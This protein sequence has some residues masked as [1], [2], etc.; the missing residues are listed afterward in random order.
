MDLSLS[1]RTEGDRTIVSVGGELA[2]TEGLRGYD[3]MHLAAALAI[4]AEILSS[5]DDDLCDAA[6]RR[7]TRRVGMYHFEIVE[8][9]RR[10]VIAGIVFHKRQLKPAHRPV[11]PPFS[12]TLLSESRAGR[13]QR[14][15]LHH[16]LTS[17]DF[18]G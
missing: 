17:I 1:T 9:E 13:R 15:R 6:A 18:H 12:R 5:A 7:Q 2:E 10:I 4:G 8:P 14:T 16:P 3:A 11:I